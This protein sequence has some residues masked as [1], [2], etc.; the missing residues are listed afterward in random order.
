MLKM[1]A[2]GEEI[3]E[4]YAANSL[5]VGSEE[6]ARCHFAAIGTPYPGD[7]AIPERWFTWVG[8]P[9]ETGN[10]GV[11]LEKISRKSSFALRTMRRR[12]CISVWRASLEII[13]DR[14]CAH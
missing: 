9:K 10:A 11:A 5:P 13:V 6:P 7:P 4:V 1:H 2:T 8:A 14:C 3:T 12:R